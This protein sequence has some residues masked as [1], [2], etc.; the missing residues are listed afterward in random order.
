[1]ALTAVTGINSR[2][3]QS[4]YPAKK[5]DNGDKKPAPSEGVTRKREDVVDLREEATR[6]NLREEVTKANRSAQRSAREGAE[7]LLGQIDLSA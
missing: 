5:T 3:I 4:E 1:M 2:R 7:V 6:A